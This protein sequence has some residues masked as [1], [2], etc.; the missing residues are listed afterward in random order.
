MH[1]L[2]PYGVDDVLRPLCSTEPAPPSSS[3]PILCSSR[4]PAND[5]RFVG[6]PG[7]SVNRSRNLRLPVPAAIVSENPLGSRSGPSTV[8]RKS[9]PPH[10]LDRSI[11]PHPRP[12]SWYGVR[13]IPPSHAPFPALSPT[14]IAIA[15]LSRICHR[16]IFTNICSSL[17]RAR[18]WIIPGTAGGSLS[19]Q[20]SITWLRHL[21][22]HPKTASGPDPAKLHLAPPHHSDGRP[23]GPHF[24]ILPCSRRHLV[25][26]VLGDFNVIT[27]SSRTWG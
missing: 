27:S 4:I 1:P 15:K 18:E 7:F 11:F 6:T 23:L 17:T 2:S 12:S 20:G 22:G 25:A 3:P 16:F 9:P 26:I 13:S 10:T 5:E 19:T 8:R 14:V 24:D 21:G